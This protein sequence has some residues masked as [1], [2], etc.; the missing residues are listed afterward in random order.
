M[1]NTQMTSS[2]GPFG[3]N[4]FTLNGR[5]RAIASPSPVHSGFADYL[6]PPETHDFIVNEMCQRLGLDPAIDARAI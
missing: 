6:A 4:D 1:N 2:H 5:R 3:A